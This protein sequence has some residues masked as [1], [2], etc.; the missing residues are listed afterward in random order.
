MTT[1]HG[2]PLDGEQLDVSALTDDEA[3]LGVALPATGGTYPGGR[4]LYSPRDDGMWRW[5]GD[6]P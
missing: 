5:D 2:G 3:A 1:L 4:S 6:T